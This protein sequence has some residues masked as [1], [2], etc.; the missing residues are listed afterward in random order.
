MRRESAQTTFIPRSSGF[1][2]IEL[3][4]VITIMT[5]LLAIL[6]PA[7]RK[8]RSVADRTICQGNL[9]QISQGWHMY[10][11]ANEGKFCQ[12]ENANA[13]YGGWRGIDY[14]D[15]PRPLNPYLGLASLPASEEDAQ[16]FKCP[17]DKGY[18]GPMYY[19]DLGTSYQTNILLIGQ[20]QIG[21]LPNGQLRH[22]INQNL[23]NL[24]QQQVDSPERVLLMGDYGWGVQWLPHYP[25]GPYWHDRN[26]YYSLAFLDGHVAFLHIR[27][28]LFITD[29]Y[30]VL[31]RKVLYALA[32][33]VQKEESI[34]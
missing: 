22:A 27:K 15:H 1:T 20:D 7:L 23:R 10:L 6:L 34:K 4:A 28:G 13:L 18:T 8:A 24:T 16:V 31:P 21:M 26:Y 25:S 32:H 9:R 30:T 11:N 33:E 12:G 19:Q 17:C 2:L 14:P 5:L 3:L 29:E